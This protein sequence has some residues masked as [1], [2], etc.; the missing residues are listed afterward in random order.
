MLYTAMLACL[1]SGL[2]YGYHRLLVREL[3]TET[4][5][6]LEGLTSGLH[7]YLKFSG[8][9]PS[10]D[11][12]RTD[13]LAVTFIEEATRYY[14]LYDVGTG[15]LLWQSAALESLGLHYTPAEVSTF[16]GSQTMAGA[17]YL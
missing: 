17:V 13:P 11:Y 7:G 10:L 9:Q 16:F 14:Q 12:N 1:L 4:D 3:E 5:A 8:G 15:G 2:A 6:T